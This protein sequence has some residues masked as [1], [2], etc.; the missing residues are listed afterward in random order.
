MEYACSLD[1]R[2]RTPRWFA[3][4]VAVPQLMMLPYKLQTY[5]LQVKSPNSSAA[6]DG[7]LLGHI[8][9]DAV[10]AAKKPERASAVA[11]FVQ[12]TAIL[13][14]SGVACLDALLTASLGESGHDLLPQA[15]A[16]S[17]PATLTAV[18]AT[19][20]GRGLDAIIRVSAAPSEAVDEFVQ[21]YAALGVAAQQR[22]WLRPMLETVAKRRAET[23]P[24]GLKLR[25]A[26]GAAFSIGD[27][28]SDAV[29]IVNMFLAGQIVGAVALL[30]MIAMNLAFQV[31]VVIVQN[32]RFGLAKVAR[33][34]FIVLSLLKPAVDAIRVA[35]GE[36]Q[37]EGAPI[38]PI[39]EM[40]ICKLSEMTF[41]SIPAGMA[42]AVFLLNG[43]DWTTVAVISLILSCLSTAFTATSIAYDL[44]TNV[45]KRKNNGEF[46]G[47][48]PD[49][50][51]GRVRA[52][53]LLLLYH[54][55]V[56]MGK[57]YSMA[58]LA[59]TKWLWLMAYLLADHFGLILYKLA[60]GDFIYWIPS[61]G[62]SL[63]LLARFVVKAVTDF[64]GYPLASY[65][66]LMR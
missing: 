53:M 28:V 30:C 24:L 50:S 14:E 12:R 57:T 42:Q 6:A 48:M 1:F 27:M 32:A 52:F 35:G 58:V 44:D 45:A 26:V 40:V 63:S 36:E 62:A 51:A 21:A 31:L 3:N 41:E 66:R 33:E 22:D 11:T 7:A 18:E 17:D 47:Y 43:G 2:G 13:R 16:T 5:F 8:L 39:A 49:T 25:L 4:S 29:Q 37:A 10:E 9:F 15:V 65:F 54:S 56:V 19:T 46:Y 60:R 55:T 23:A 61:F 59:Q 64:T 34:I 20:I 38:D